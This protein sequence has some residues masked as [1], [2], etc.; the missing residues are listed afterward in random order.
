MELV[1]IESPYAGRDDTETQVNVEYA[2]ACVRDC[3][4]RNESPYASHLLLTQPG[5]LD[6]KIP[7]ERTRGIEAGFAFRLVVKNTKVYVDRG[8]STGMMLG[9]KLARS[10]GHDVQ[11][12]SLYGNDALVQKTFQ[13][14]LED[15]PVQETWSDRMVPFTLPQDPQA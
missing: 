14:S 12:R 4:T 9:I 7:E 15:M 13:M 10:F 1:I 2:R 3:L 5:V 8:L 11:F 6:D